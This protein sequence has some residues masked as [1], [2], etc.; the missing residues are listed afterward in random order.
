MIYCALDKGK[1]KAE[2]NAVK[3][4]RM[5][6][7]KETA[8]W[9]GAYSCLDTLKLLLD[10]IYLDEYEMQQVNEYYKSLSEL[11]IR[12]RKEQLKFKPELLTEEPFR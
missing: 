10:N 12:K 9:Y 6:F 8:E 3:Q 1:F 2:L 11:K 7:N 4:A 5:Y